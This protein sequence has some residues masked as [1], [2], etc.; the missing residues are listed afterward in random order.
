VLVGRRVSEHDLEQLARHDKLR[1]FRLP[2]LASHGEVAA[3][4]RESALLL[5]EGRRLTV[6]AVLRTWKLDADLVV[7]S[8]CESG[9]GQYAGGDGR[10]GFAHALLSRGARSVVLSRW[11]VDDRATALLMARFC[12]N[13]LGKRAGLN[14]GMGRAEA[15]AE[16]KKW[17][18]TLPRTD[19]E[20]L[21]ARLASGKLRGTIDDPLPEVKPA[22]KLPA[23]DRPF[24]APNYWA[25]F[26]LVGDPS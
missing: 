5:S 2:H 9:L 19:A 1:R 6:G 10:L 7:L 8:A 25:A 21:A 26:V 14:K 22:A 18:R 24:A 11:K 4:P 15:L 20:A 12:E 3:Q 16:P 17:L 13:L 23:G